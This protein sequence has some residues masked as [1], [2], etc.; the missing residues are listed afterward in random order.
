MKRCTKCAE[1]K[2]LEAFVK[3]KRERNGRAARCKA[4]FNTDQRRRY[5]ANDHREHKRQYEAANRAYIRKDNRER[6]QRWRAADPERAKVQ[7]RKDSEQFRKA[8]PNYHRAW[9]RKNLAK[10]RARGRKVARQW[11]ARYP[12]RARALRYS[13]RDQLGQLSMHSVEYIRILLSDPC[14]YCGCPAN[15]I[16]HI[17]ARSIGGA[18]EWPNYTAACSSCN[19]SKRD[20]HLL[21]WLAD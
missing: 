2:A 10:E 20:K 9:Y 8:N 1:T 3:D 13:V 17:T 5:V 21:C 11:R 4:C 14:S 12:D 18:D 15:S 16:D 6:T 19:S 7:S